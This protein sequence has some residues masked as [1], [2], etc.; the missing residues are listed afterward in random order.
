LVSTSSS[1]RRHVAQ[2]PR[3]RP[4][5][6]QLNLGTEADAVIVVTRAVDLA[7]RIEDRC[8]PLSGITGRGRLIAAM[9]PCRDLRCAGAG[10][11]LADTRLATRSGAGL[12]RPVTAEVGRTSRIPGTRPAGRCEACILRRPGRGAVTASSRSCSAS[13]MIGSHVPVATTTPWCS[14][15]RARLLGSSAFR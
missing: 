3:T 8:G 4:R 14:F 12:S 2:V 7:R 13:V 1:D 15:P 6:S 9:S 5:R 11:A 10:T